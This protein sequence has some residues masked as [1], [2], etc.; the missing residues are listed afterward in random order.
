MNNYPA[1]PH[2]PHPHPLSHAYTYSYNPASGPT[3]T[4]TTT[5]TTAGGLTSLGLSPSAS[6]A[7]Q[8]FNA[9]SVRR[10]LFQAQLGRRPATGMGRSDSTGS[11]GSG[12]T[13]RVI[14]DAD[15]DAEEE[16]DVL[17]V[18]MGDGGGEMLEIVV[19][20]RFGEVDV[21]E[22]RELAVDEGEEFDVEDRQ[23]TESGFI[24]TPSGQLLMRAWFWRV[25]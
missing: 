2:V 1:L 3:T 17:G 5:T 25:C 22:P 11:G 21:L 10:N 24:F 19:R 6:A 20:D 18:G 9:A 23:E 16:R 7:A 15:A 13:V 12:E 14:A 4:T 8:A